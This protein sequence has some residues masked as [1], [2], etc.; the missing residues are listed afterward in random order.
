VTVRPT[1][2]T[3]WPGWKSSKNK[4]VFKGKVDMWLSSRN[5]FYIINVQRAEKVSVYAGHV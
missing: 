3:F 4:P 2:L 1:E 5:G